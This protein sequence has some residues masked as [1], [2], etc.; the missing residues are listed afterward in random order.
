M[1]LFFRTKPKYTSMYQNVKEFSFSIGLLLLLMI[2]SLDFKPMARLDEFIIFC[3][4]FIFAI[5]SLG[6]F[7]KEKKASNSNRNISADFNRF[8]DSCVSILNNTWR[9]DRICRLFQESY[10]LKNYLFH[11]FFKN[12]PNI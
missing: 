11:G 10:K 8:H 7:T 1:K 4:L 12:S 3:L 9:L 2:L 6:I 5:T